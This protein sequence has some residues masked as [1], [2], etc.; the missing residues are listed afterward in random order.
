MTL[1]VH[2]DDLRGLLY[3]SL[4]IHNIMKP[5]SVFHNN[6]RKKSVECCN[7]KNNKRLQPSESCKLCQIQKK[8]SVKRANSHAQSDSDRKYQLIAEN[9]ADYISIMDFQGIY[10]YVSPSH[11]KLGYREEDL[12]GKCGFDMIP[13]E[14]KVKLTPL[15]AKYAGMK[16]QQA[17]KLKKEMHSRPIS[18]RFPDSKGKFHYMEAT[19]SFINS[20]DTK[21]IN[22]LM[23][24]RDVTERI[25]MEEQLKESEERYRAL[26]ELGTEAGEAIVMIQDIDGREGI[27]TFV[28]DHWAI[29]TGYPKKELTGSNFFELISDSDRQPS[30]ERHR[31]RMSGKTLSGMFEMNILRKDGTEIPV[32]FTGAFTTY[33][34]QRANVLYLRDISAHKQYEQKLRQSEEHFSSL[35]NEV[36][37]A[38]WDLD[39]SQTK[40]YIDEL[41]GKGISDFRRY[42]DDN[43]D[44]IL[45]CLKLEGRRKPYVNK[46]AARFWEAD[47]M[48]QL[49]DGI[50]SLI[51][52]R[53]AGLSYDKENIL[54]MI[55][56]TNANS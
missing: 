52:K 19:A 55:E 6:V 10:E 49:R 35:Y 7:F 56:G 34:G 5:E 20:P 24:S 32:E 4:D 17:L 14:D 46:T 39:Y 36:P 54:C 8:Q 16:I 38:I 45:H 31:Q 2:T 44:E 18:F 3:R 28:N 13:Q 43:P 22:I 37:I 26:I 1:L 48:E 47:S 11:R 53:P 9:T 51:S 27:Q 15:I 21:G 50:F 30:I 25:L 40:K 42:F 41:R 23:V 29:I 12:L 33:Q